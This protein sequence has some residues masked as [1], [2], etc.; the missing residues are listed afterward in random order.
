MSPD[1]EQAVSTNDEPLMA[2]VGKASAIALSVAGSVALA[3]CGRMVYVAWSGQRLFNSWSTIVF[4]HIMPAAVAALCFSSLALK[5][6]ARVRVL[7]LIASLTLSLYAAEVWLT[8]FPGAGGGVFASLDDHEQLRPVMSSLAIARDKTRFAADLTRRF[9]GSIDVRSAREMLDEFRSRGHEAVPILTPSNHLFIPQPDGSIRSAVTI[10]GDEV[11]P[12]AGVSR[13]LTLL[14][15]EGGQWVDYRSDRW[16]FN[17]PDRVWDSGPPDI[18]ALGD[19][20]TQGYCVEADKNFVALIRDHDG[21]TINLGIAGDGPLLML[22][23]LAEFA[24]VRAPKIVLWF[25]YEGND[26]V[27]L[28]IERKSA[29]LSRY[30]TAG[31]SQPR[32]ATQTEID[33]GILAEI[34]RLE[35][36]ERENN[37]RRGRNAIRHSLSTFAVLGSLRDRLGLVEGSEPSAAEAARDF[38]TANMAVFQEVLRQAKT[39]V[40][41]W[42]G[43]LYFVYLPEWTRYTSYSSWGKA[44]RDETLRLVR[45]LGIPVIDIDPVFEAHGDPLSLFPFRMVGHYNET[46]HRLVADAVLRRLASGGR[47]GA[48]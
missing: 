10:D 18:V 29:L 45:S 24:A 26:L 37:E 22:A 12:L 16:G 6:R 5:P 23:T 27:D 31:F 21:A 43:Q 19:S 3:A 25:Y 4:Y 41:G 13:R 8:I 1:D 36:T 32:L 2:S 48:P 40:D 17:N 15:N 35:K 33:R 30:L 20:F 11:M 38:D 14:C 7:L 44:K 34:P 47:H 42:Q 46:G 39:H 9:G 28:Q